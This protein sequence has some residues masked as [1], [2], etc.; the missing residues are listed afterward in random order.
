M[1]NYIQNKLA[2]ISENKQMVKEFITFVKGEDTDFDLNKITPMPEILKDT[3]EGSET[4][5]GLYYYL[6]KNNLLEEYP[7]LIDKV[8]TSV[9]DNIEKKACSELNRLYEVGE[10]HFNA[11]KETGYV[12][13]YK[14]CIDNW[15]TKWN[16][17]DSSI[18]EDEHGAIFFFTTAWDGI[19]M[20][21]DKLHELFP[22][23]KFE[24]LY[25]DEDF[26]CN[27]GVGFTNENGEFEFRAIEDNSDEA[28]QTYIEC[29]NEDEEDFVKHNGYWT[30]KDY[31]EDEFDDEE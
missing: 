25:A 2:V 24:Y 20:L 21:I 12:S 30:R 18:Y 17:S 4:Y 6:K 26:T 11:Y 8:F 9:F 14:W 19:P 31:L 3:I 16:T 28:F 29:W 27:C 7:Q 23:L 13:W 22:N 10:H 15:G 5:T 1:P